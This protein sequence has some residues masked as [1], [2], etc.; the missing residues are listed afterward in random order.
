V[1]KWFVPGRGIVDDQEEG[2]H[3][4]EPGSITLPNGEKITWGVE[5]T[6]K[7]PEYANKAQYGHDSFQWDPEHQVMAGRIEETAPGYVPELLALRN[8]VRSGQA[9]DYEVE[10]YTRWEEQARA[11]PTRDI[12]SLKAGWQGEREGQWG[13]N[14]WR[15]GSK[16]WWTHLDPGSPDA[17]PI[18]LS[19]VEKL[20]SGKATPHERELFAKVYGMAADWDWRANVP[21]ASDAFNPLGDQFF[22]ALGVLGLGAS[23]GLAA[24]PLFAGGAGLATTLGSLGTLSGI[25][26]TGAG[27]IG[28][29]IDEPWLQQLGL[30][31]SAAGGLAGGVGGLANV[32][33]SGITSVADAARLAQSAGKVAG[34]LGRIP[35]ADPLRQAG[36]YLGL[37]GQLGR[38]FSGMQNLFGAAQGVTRGAIEGLAPRTTSILESLQR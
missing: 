17:G 14:G 2:A 32:A 3:I 10:E 6:R 22:G 38:G 28:Q 5:G 21:Q 19:L 7:L 4:P 20:E 35:G 18:M 24:A 29:A 36:R 37:A 8:R 26:G 27:V 11:I 15:E 30:G 23:G 25:A 13:D 1:A 16:D 33:R 31:L 9:Q 12:T 34:S